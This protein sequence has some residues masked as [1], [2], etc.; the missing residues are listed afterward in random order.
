MLHM[1]SSYTPLHVAVA[2]DA[3][4]AAE[5]LLKQGADVNARTDDDQTP[6]SMAKMK[7]N[8]ENI[9]QVLLRYGGRE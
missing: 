9:V 1:L 2:F 4:E 7:E 5:M 6:L 8:K 3:S